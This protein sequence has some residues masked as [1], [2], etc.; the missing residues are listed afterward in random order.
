MWSSPASN[1]RNL[2]L[3]V[4]AVAGV[5]DLDGECSLRTWTNLI[6]A[7]PPQE[8]GTIFLAFGP[9]MKPNWRP[10]PWMLERLTDGMT[11]RQIAPAVM[12]LFNFYFRSGTINSHPASV[13]AASLTE[14]LGD[15]TE[16]MEQIES[17][18]ARQ[19]TPE[20]TAR[21]VGDAVA[22]IVS[23]CDALA[24][25]GHTGGIDPI[26]RAM[27]LRHRR[28]QAEAAAALAKLGDLSGR[29][30]L[31]ELAQE[32]SVRLRVLA[33]AEELGIENEISLE[34]R[35]EIARAESHL[36]IWLSEP[37]QMGIAP[38]QVSLIDSRELYW[39]SYEHPVQ[40]YLFKFRFGT[41]EKG[42][43]NVGICGPLTHA[44]SNDLLHL[45]VEDMY[46]AF[47]G[48]QTIHPDIFT[49]SV[50][51]AE[52]SFANDLRRLKSTL[53]SDPELE[54]VEYCTVGSFFGQLVLVATGKTRIDGSER[55][56]TLVADSDQSWFIDRGNPN[57]PIDWQMAFGIW[58]GRQ[59]LNA[60]NPAS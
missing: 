31:I 13:R 30:K 16:R 28:V 43:A 22:M 57:S 47:A 46:A 10:P 25:V 49:M 19:N 54:D 55:A 50:E 7:D 48:W 23:L 40:C 14:L 59:L 56:G 2:T 15:L 3:G 24:L 51:T 38:N 29:E 33:F 60:F 17:G 21:Q 45:P 11:H 32:P 4:L 9:L 52:K 35:G 53:N 39:P 26:K 42:Y 27:N 41:K 12:D 37:T 20:E 8:A 5:H 18:G 34:L 6:T 58:R 44:F 36:A 1:L